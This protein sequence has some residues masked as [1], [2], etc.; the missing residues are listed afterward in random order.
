[1]SK[2]ARTKRTPLG[3][4]RLR[5]RAVTSNVPA[6]TFT[7]EMLEG[8]AADL[9]SGR[10]PLPRVNV[11][12]DVQV[13]LRAIIRNTGNISFHANYDYQDSRPWFKIGDYPDMSIKKAREL[14]FTIRELASKGIDVQAGMHERLLRELEERGTKWRPKF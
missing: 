4:E 1:M 6:A 3:G 5:K 11:S 2:A 14:T 8:L 9:K 12:D 13:G 10:I 7:G